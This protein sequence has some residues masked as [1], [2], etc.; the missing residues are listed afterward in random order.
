[1]THSL[2]EWSEF[3]EGDDN[4]RYMNYTFGT[5]DAQSLW[6]IIRNQVFGNTVTGINMLDCSIV[7]CSSEEGWDDYILLHHFDPT[8]PTED[9]NDFEQ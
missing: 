7:V 4:G 8:E 1:M 5:N 6:N 9:F 3:S 2:V